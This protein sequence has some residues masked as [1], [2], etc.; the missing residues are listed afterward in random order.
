MTV[1]PRAM[2]DRAFIVT[3]SEDGQTSK[4]Y[5]ILSPDAEPEAV[6]THPYTFTFPTQIVPEIT[7]AT[8]TS[9]EGNTMKYC[10]WAPLSSHQDAFAMSNGAMSNS[11]AIT[12]ITG[13]N[14]SVSMEYNH[15]SY[16]SKGSLIGLGSGKTTSS[17]PYAD[18][19]Y[20]SLNGSIT[21]GATSDHSTY[22]YGSSVSDPFAA[23][24]GSRQ[25]ITL[26]YNNGTLTVTNKNA[27]G[28]ETSKAIDV[29][30]YK[31]DYES[32]AKYIFF[33]SN[34]Q[35]YLGGTWTTAPNDL[36]SSDSARNMYFYSINST[37]TTSGRDEEIYGD[38]NFSGFENVSTSIQD[39]VNA[40]VY[41]GNATRAADN[42][43]T[44]T[45]L[46]NG[47]SM[48]SVLWTYGVGGNSS[49]SQK[50][51]SEWW[52]A[53]V[54]F[55]DITFLYDG[56]TTMECPI[57]M[58]HSSVRQS[59]TQYYVAPT[60]CGTE[61]SNYVSLNHIWHGV[62]DSPVYATDTKY[63]ISTSGAQNTSYT[64]SLAIKAGFLNSPVTKYYS[65]S[66]VLR[67]NNL[68]FSDNMATVTNTVWRF[69]NKY[70]ND[71]PG[72]ATYTATATHTATIRVLNYEPIVDAYE[73]VKSFYK[74]NVQYKENIYTP[75]SL[76]AYYT[77]LEKFFFN[78]NNSFTTS[79]TD[80]NGYADCQRKLNEAIANID[81]ALGN[82][83]V[84][85][86]VT[87]T[88]N[89][90]NGTIKK[91]IYTAGT[92]IPTPNFGTGTVVENI[93]DNFTQHREITY[94]WPN[95][96][97][98]VA[99]NNASYSET[100]TG[101]SIVDCSFAVAD[102]STNDN[103][104]FECNKNCSNSYTVDMSAYNAAL[105]KYEQIIATN[106]YDMIYTSASR[107]AYAQAIE[108]ARSTITGV[109]TQSDVEGVLTDI[110]TA[111]NLVKQLY[112]VR[113]SYQ[114]DGEETQYTTS[115]C[116][117]G[118]TFT[119]SLPDSVE[120]TVYKWVMSSGTQDVKVDTNSRTF[121]I[122]ANLE[123][124]YTCFIVSNKE[125]E[126]SSNT[127]KLSILSKSNRIGDIAYVSRGTYS[128][129]IQDTA[130]SV[131]TVSFEAQK[132]AF[133]NITGFTVNGDEI[134][135]G[136]TIEI[137]ADTVITPIYTPMS[138]LTISRADINS[139]ILINGKERYEAKWD[140]RITLTGQN[141]TENTAW[142]FDGVLVGYGTEYSFHA[143]KACTVSYD[144]S[145][146]SKQGIARIDY[147]NYGEYRKK[148]A[149]V[150][151][152]YSIPDDCTIVKTGVLMKTDRTT[153]FDS[154]SNPYIGATTLTED[155]WT[156]AVQGTNGN[157]TTEKQISTNQYMICVSRTADTSFIMGAVAYIVYE[158]SQGET[159]TAFSE[160]SLIS[161]KTA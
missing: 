146:T 110:E 91:K 88:Y 134:S 114:I 59:S 32:G 41:S 5:T 65:N 135:D 129:S 136:D 124:S 74:N 96:M 23:S 154:T 133:Y 90:G 82:E 46:A 61:S 70:T 137:T 21:I 19:V 93:A 142:Y 92:T 66:F 131:G 54:Q 101:S 67:P 147:F 112:P 108:N 104:H 45:G 80:G 116:E 109:F 71:V 140:E 79:S 55:G 138:V 31:A 17:K 14:W 107:E 69:G 128:V 122:V 161:Y 121:D 72:S 34:A 120:G 152:A 27:S 38:T 102:D 44:S 26:A 4:L 81:K 158:D 85:R 7:D 56:K 40:G 153:P 150:V 52:N 143:T 125:S 64:G 47:D 75:S 15:T 84:K 24:A 99:L 28:V 3:L 117:Y 98:R 103:K 130:I 2:E 36:N 132:P 13:N 97:Q 83:L 9:T 87:I 1:V 77:A 68:S 151:C 127:V 113:F 29:S 33:G 100:I 123:K 62:A 73:S 157:Y 118:E 141:T 8:V 155:W 145:N 126:S 63:S 18:L 37:V 42:S 76:Q 105:Q 119:L 160:L 25:T 139:D 86:K 60:G 156:A 51:P 10:N 58:Y 16:T 144:N 106:N 12:G 49:H 78:P 53:G 35:N 149:S 22:L 50:G 30:A 95:T 20:V 6:I 57:N 148:T 111:S 11:T 39:L 115:N 43:Y 159:H 48:S 89:F 94:A